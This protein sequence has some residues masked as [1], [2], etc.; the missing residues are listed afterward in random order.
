MALAENSCPSCRSS[1]RMRTE[2]PAGF[3]RASRSIR[4]RAKEERRP[5]GGGGAPWAV[6]LVE[7]A[8]GVVGL[9][10]DAL[11]AEHGVPG[12]D[13]QGGVRLGDHLGRGE[14]EPVTDLRVAAVEQ[15]G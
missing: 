12:A 15:A 1:P 10:E 6:G 13:R 8:V 3:S 9:A 2:P 4:A 5:A 14:R 7:R 11:L